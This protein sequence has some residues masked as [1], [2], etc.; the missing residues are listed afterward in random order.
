MVDI[1]R[2]AKPLSRNPDFQASSGW[3]ANFLNRHLDI[4]KLVKSKKFSSYPPVV[5]QE[6]R[7]FVA[8]SSISQKLS[9][10]A[11]YQD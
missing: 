11:L 6:L 10:R 2:H 3:C 4:K 1:C 8:P 9:G 5:K 7:G